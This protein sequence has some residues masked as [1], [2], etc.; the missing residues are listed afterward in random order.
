MN[1]WLLENDIFKNTKQNKNGKQNLNA[2]RLCLNV[3]IKRTHL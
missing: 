2:K 3:N 1:I